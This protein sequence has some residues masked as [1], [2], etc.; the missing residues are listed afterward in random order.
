M[1]TTAKLKASCLP[2]AS[3]PL[4]QTC[5]SREKVVSCR[6][7]PCPFPFLIPSSCTLKA[8]KSCHV[9]T[10]AQGAALPVSIG[11]NESGFSVHRADLTRSVASVEGGVPSAKLTWDQSSLRREVA[12]FHPLCQLPS[13]TRGL[14]QGF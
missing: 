2:P 4:P 3:P 7:L 13:V 6:R 10:G 11:R 9:G 12:G 14:C 8:H 5:R 1:L